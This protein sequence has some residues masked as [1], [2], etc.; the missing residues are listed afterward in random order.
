MRRFAIALSVISLVLLGL[1]TS[2]GSTSGAQS[3]TPDATSD[4]PIVGTWQKANDAPGPGV[5][6]AYAIFHADGTYLE[7]DPNI[8]VGLG[9]WRA[10]GERTADLTAVY[11]DIDSDP[12]VSAEGTVTVRQSVAVDESGSAFTAPFT[13][14]VRI[15][16][17]TVVFTAKYTARGTRLE[18]EPMSPPGTPVTAAPAIGTPTG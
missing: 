14:E 11:Q 6:S 7:V 12:A 2:R 8:G 18:I 3:A 17:G 15:P 13:I 10:T 9:V 4:H 16:D 1:L 5:N